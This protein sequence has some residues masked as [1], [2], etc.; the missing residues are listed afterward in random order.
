MYYLACIFLQP[1]GV[2][3][4]KE[5]QSLFLWYEKKNALIGLLVVYIDSSLFAGAKHFHKTIL[6]KVRERFLVGEEK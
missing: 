1:N 5:N 6:L 4:S 3:T 2:V